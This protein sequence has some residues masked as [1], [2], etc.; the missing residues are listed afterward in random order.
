MK[1]R[2]QK[3]EHDVPR[4]KIVERYP[5]SLENLFPALQYCRRAYI[6]DNSSKSMKLIAEKNPENSL[7]ILKEDPIPIWIDEYVLQKVND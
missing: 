6:F 1:E 7:T 3:G 2:V 5:R 4:D